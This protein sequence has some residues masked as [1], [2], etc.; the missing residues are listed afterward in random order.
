MPSPT[1]STQ[2]YVPPPYPTP[3]PTVPPRRGRKLAAAL[4]LVFVLLAAA[5]TRVNPQAVGDW[6]KLRGYTPPSDVVKLADQDTMNSYTKHLFYLNRPQLLPTVTSFREHCPE[7]KDTIV[8]GC[9][10]SGQNG[11]FV[12]NVQ[13]PTLAGIQQVTAAHEVL[14]AVYARLSASERRSLDSQL[15]DF[16]KHG[17]KDQRVIDEVKLYQKTEP[18]D[19]MDEMSC[20]FG[21]ELSSLPSGLEAYYRRYFTDRQAI[22]AYERQYE[23]E[24]TRRESLIKHYDAQLA[25]LKKQIDSAESDLQAK[26]ARINAEQTQ[27]LSEQSSDV[28]AYNAG[29]PAYNQLVDAYNAEISSTQALINSYNGLVDTRNRVAG[30]LAELDK[31]IDTRL[32][33]AATR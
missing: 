24:F 13:D 16:Y 2:T 11:I 21:T 28:N 29:V 12:Y 18:N 10:H 32:T 15:E 8:L 22:V 25:S 5:A 31:A 27:L 30:Q 1:N 4:V 19:V 20:T 14:H 3:P 23:S 9:Y 6:W 7:N 33:P 26:Q 17:L